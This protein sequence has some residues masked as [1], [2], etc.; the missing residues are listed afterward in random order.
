MSQVL[1]VQEAASILPEL[2]KRVAEGDSVLIGD[3]GRAEASLQAVQNSPNRGIKIGF[4]SNKK[5]VV[6][7]D[8]DSPLPDEILKGF[9]Y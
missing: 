9:G 5:L 4:Y 6:T 3:D 1:S 7:D 2:I 8:F